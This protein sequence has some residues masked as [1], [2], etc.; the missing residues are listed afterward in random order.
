MEKV[1]GKRYS[2]DVGDDSEE[3]YLN[4]FLGGGRCSAPTVLLW[5]F[6]VCGFFVLF[7]L[8]LSLLL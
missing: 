7:S 3:L 5:V 1:V 6:S 8:S 4:L 2:E